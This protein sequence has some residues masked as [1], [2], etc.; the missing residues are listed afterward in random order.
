VQNNQDECGGENSK[1]PDGLISKLQRNTILCHPFG[2]PFMINGHFIII[3]PL[4]G[5]NS[6]TES[7]FQHR[8]NPEGME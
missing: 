1:S 3:P 8:F 4:C 6:V 2:I 7:N 5:F